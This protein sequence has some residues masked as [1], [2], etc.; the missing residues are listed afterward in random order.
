MTSPSSREDCAMCKNARWVCEAHPDRP[1]GVE[2]G[3]RCGGA[4]MP[5]DFCNPAGGLDDPPD[6]P[7]GF[8]T[9]KVF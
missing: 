8:V 1:W 9:K 5:C 4:G 3:C 7:P 6:M 2:G